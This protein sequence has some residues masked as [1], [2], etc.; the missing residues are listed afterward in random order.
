[1]PRTVL[2]HLNVELPDDDGA[3]VPDLVQ[4]ITD[5]LSIAVEGDN[6]PVLNASTV[7]IPL[8]EEV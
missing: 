5:A 2:V 7:V 4:E 1:M 6:A 8:A 3:T